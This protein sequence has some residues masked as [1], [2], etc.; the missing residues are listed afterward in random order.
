MI[1]KLKNIE[2]YNNI[3]HEYNFILNVYNV[4]Y[5]DP[6]RKL[7]PSEYIFFRV[8]SYSFILSSFIKT[9]LR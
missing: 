4:K 3:S 1:L 6:F 8:A 7:L 9:A 2:L 5:S